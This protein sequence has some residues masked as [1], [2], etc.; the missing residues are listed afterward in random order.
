MVLKLLT[1]RLGRKNHRGENLFPRNLFL[2]A[3]FVDS[4]VSKNLNVCTHASGLLR[5]LR[6]VIVDSITLI[7]ELLH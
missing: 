7:P 5:K 6:G 4:M 1:R 3:S 2:N